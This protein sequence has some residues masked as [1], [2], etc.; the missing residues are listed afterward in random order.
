MSELK[1]GK[2]PVIV[3]SWHCAPLKIS[4]QSLFAPVGR[5]HT[6]MIRKCARHS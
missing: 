2:I 3:P 6:F 4:V 5:K 1:D